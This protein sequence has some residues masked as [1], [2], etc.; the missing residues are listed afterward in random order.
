MEKLIRFKQGIDSLNNDE[1]RQFLELYGRKNL[2]KLIFNDILCDINHNVTKS[3]DNTN[4]L[5]TR[6][7]ASRKNQQES[8]KEDEDVD[9]TAINTNYS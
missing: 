9:I 2:I 4:Q 8:K 1:Y 3:A 6:I 5:I 7:I